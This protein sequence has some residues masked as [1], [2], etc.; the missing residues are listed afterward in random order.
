MKQ[1][2]IN[3]EE[4]QKFLNE[5]YP[6]DTYLI[7]PRGYQKMTWGEEFWIFVNE[8]IDKRLDKDVEMSVSEISK[9]SHLFRLD[10]YLICVYTS[11]KGEELK[12]QLKSIFYAI[13]YASEGRDS[14]AVEKFVEWFD[15]IE[16]IGVEE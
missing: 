10:N 2:T 3:I 6:E 4:V 8:M 13:D 1:W 9:I 11:A 14:Y 12:N 7:E 5:E 15:K 16:K